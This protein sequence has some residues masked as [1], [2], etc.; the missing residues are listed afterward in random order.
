MRSIEMAAL[1]LAGVNWT[2][3]WN[4]PERRGE[5]RVLLIALWQECG[6]IPALAERTGLSQSTIKLWRRTDEAFR[7]A[8]PTRNGRP[9]K[10]GATSN[11]AANTTERKRASGE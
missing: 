11:A 7:L 3:A 1:E 4:D 10:K 2:K 8:T 9:P 6:T 5:A